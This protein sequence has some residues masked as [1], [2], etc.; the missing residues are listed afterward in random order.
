MCCMAD[1]PTQ[2]NIGIV[3]TMKTENLFDAIIENLL[4]HDLDYTNMGEV[5]N[6]LLN[7]HNEV[8]L[9]YLNSFWFIKFREISVG[10]SSSIVSNRRD[11]IA[12][13]L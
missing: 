2:I 7:Q 6:I 3:Y 5:C 1:K 8:Y 4:M 9:L 11:Q 12:A 10:L 13:S